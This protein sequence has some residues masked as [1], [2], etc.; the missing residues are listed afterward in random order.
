LEQIRAGNDF[1]Q[2]ELVSYLVSESIE[3]RAR[4]N[5]QLAEAFVSARQYRKAKVFIDRAW[6]FSNFSD[7]VFELYKQIC[8]HLNDFD[9]LRA[10]YKRIGIRYAKEG[11][12]NQALTAFNNWQYVYATYLHLDKYQYDIDILE[13][14][15]NLAIPHELDKSNQVLPP[16]QGRRIRL[17]YLVYGASHANSVLVKIMETFANFHDQ[18]VF[19]VGFFVPESLT[20]GQK[21]RTSKLLA[22]NGAKFFVAPWSYKDDSPDSLTT[23][24][25]EIR[26]FGPDLLITTAGLAAFEHYFLALLRPAPLVVSLLQGPPQQFTARGFDHAISWSRHPLIDSPVDTTLVKLGVSLP[27]SAQIPIISR[28]ELGI[29]DGA[30]ILMSAGRYVKFQNRE[31]WQNLIELLRAQSDTYYVV[32]GAERNQV[33]CISDFAI[34]LVE[35]GRICFLGWRKDCLSLLKCA[36]IVIDTYPSGGGHVLVDAMAIGKPFVSFTNDYL[37]AFDQTDWSVAEEFVAIPELIVQR[38]NFGKFNE[39]ITKLISDAG[40]RNEM[41]EKCYRQ[42]RIEMPTERAGVLS[43]ENEYVRLLNTKGQHVDRLGR[44]D[45]IVQEKTTSTIF[46]KSITRIK[47]IVKHVFT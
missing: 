43:L 47:K 2:A 23:F 34:D 45:C 36:D 29:P 7:S 16:I 5:Y 10:A 26:K 33:P 40:F 17:A 24:A 30:V 46:H 22:S 14:I 8:E 39:M 9:A 25:S 37:H 3:Q 35:S 15:K 32:V 13:A 20:L 12:I 21:S 6:N 27:D 31:F 42:I 28:N 44:P 41:G 1:D 4:L 18:T 38:G 19:D 11:H